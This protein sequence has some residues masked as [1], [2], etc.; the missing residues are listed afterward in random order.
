MAMCSL[1]NTW[2]DSAA[3]RTRFPFPVP[4]GLPLT[5]PAPLPPA[6][7]PP[8]LLPAVPHQ[9]GVDQ[10]VGQGC[11]PVGDGGAVLLDPGG[12]PALP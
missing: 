10:R 12:T 8:S 4:P 2:P 3:A 6:A 1:N 5:S 7:L 11:E 9:R